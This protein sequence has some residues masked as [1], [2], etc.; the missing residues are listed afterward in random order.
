MWTAN[1]LDSAGNPCDGCPTCLGSEDSLLYPQIQQFQEKAKKYQRWEQ[2]LEEQDKRLKAEEERRE[3]EGSQARNP[4]QQELEEKSQSKS[5]GAKRLRQTFETQQEAVKA[6][7]DRGLLELREEADR[8]LAAAQKRFEE[9]YRELDRAYQEVATRL[10]QRLANLEAEQDLA[11]AAFRSAVATERKILRTEAQRAYREFEQER[12]ETQKQCPHPS[13][14]P[15]TSIL[16]RWPKKGS[17]PIQGVLR[18]RVCHKAFS[19]EQL[20]E[21][22]SRGATNLSY[23]PT[24]LYRGGDPGRATTH[25]QGPNPSSQERGGGGRTSDPHG[26]LEEGFGRHQKEP[27]GTGGSPQGLREES[28]DHPEQESAVQHSPDSQGEGMARDTSTRRRVGGD[29]GDE[30]SESPKSSESGEAQD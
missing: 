14:E 20:V 10:T 9:Q 29:R 25:S 18:C 27:R 17:T 12:Q 7:Y 5:A 4:I 6:E 3:L 2:R 13:S 28:R 19:Y 1:H 11:R 22:V 24:P 30:S 23:A 21:N 15:L 16:K 26:L 8:G